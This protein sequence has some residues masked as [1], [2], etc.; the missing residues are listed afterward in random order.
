MILAD[1]GR[2]V[3][4]LHPG[5][6]Q[7]VDDA[8]LGKAMQRRFPGLYDNFVDKPELNANTIPETPRTLQ[9][10][11]EQLRDGLRQVVFVARGAKA[12]IKPELYGAKRHRAPSGDFYF[13]PKM[14]KIS[15]IDAAIHNHTLNELLGATHA[16]YGAPP[17]EKLQGPVSAVV[18][19]TPEGETIQGALTDAGH[20][21]QT[22]ESAKPVTP[23]GGSI[24][25][26]HPAKELVRRIKFHR[27]AAGKKWP[28]PR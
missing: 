18:S 2:Q 28:P 1:L 23:V 4:E 20:Q 19:R 5:A 27:Q 11:M 26:E 6:Y 3:K 16:G 14:V 9:I 13:N 10:Q 17:K 12:A 25:V 7:T 8:T 24:T 22:V 15:E 21:D